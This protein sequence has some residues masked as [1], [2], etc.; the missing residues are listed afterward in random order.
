MP[1]SLQSHIHHGQENPLFSENNLIF[2]SPDLNLE[3]LKPFSM[4]K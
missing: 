3:L 2:V 4:I 1:N